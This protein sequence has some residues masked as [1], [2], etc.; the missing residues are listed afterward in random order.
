LALNHLLEAEPWARERLAPFAGQTVELRSP[1]LPPLRVIV[2]PGGLVEAGGEDPALTIT[3]KPDAL[4]NLARGEEHFMRSVEVSGDP[5]FA[6]EVMTLVRHLR[7]DMEED[8]SKLFGD[9]A[10][11][12]LANAA[13][14]L[15][16]WHAEA[17]RRLVE[18]LAD[19][20]VEEER[21][22]IP[23]ADMERF[24][25]EVARLR[26]AVERLEKRLQRL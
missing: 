24:A 7:W 21:I 25:A 22:L 5:A 18:S 23:R 13:R 3:V 9:I 6:A 1:P 16:A 12:R 26:D 15:A 20:A 4:S 19:Y 17:A 8:L 10:A 2:L 11:H 14:D